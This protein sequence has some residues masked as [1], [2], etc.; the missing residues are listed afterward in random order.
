MAEKGRLT[1]YHVLFM[2]L[3]FFGVMIAVNVLFTVFAVTSF[4]GEQEEKSYLQGINFNQ[5]LHERER[6]AE[7]GYSSAIGLEASVSGDARLVA[8]WT[9]QFENGVT[10]LSVTA[11]LSRP[12]SAEGQRVLELTALGAGRYE[13][14]LNSSLEPGAWHAL[15]TAVTPDGERLV[16]RKSLTWIR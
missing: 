14:D 8:L 13:A 4:P 3:G 1:G 2:L 10:G 9:D 5:T 11:E 6:Q 16:A 7:L 12:A 15:V